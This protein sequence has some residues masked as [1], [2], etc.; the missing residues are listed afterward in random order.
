MATLAWKKVILGGN[1]RQP[2][3]V[4][5]DGMQGM[6]RTLN[7]LAVGGSASGFDLSPMRS[8]LV[9]SAASMFS[10]GWGD[11]LIALEWD[12]RS[13]AGSVDETVADFVAAE[14]AN[15]D[16]LTGFVAALDE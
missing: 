1:M 12:A 15:L 11:A 16:A 8:D 13:L 5:Y 10:R 6:T 4:D 3:H 7:G 2:I 9:T 14:Q